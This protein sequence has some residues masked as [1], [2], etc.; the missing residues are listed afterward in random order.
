MIK[1]LVDIAV[2]APALLLLSPVMLVVAFC[3]RAT[4]GAPVLFRQMR[5]GLGFVPFEILKFRTMEAS[6]SG[7][8]V[9]SDGDPRVTA[10]G[11]VLRRTKLDEL[12]QLWNVLRGD[13]SLVGPRPEVPQYAEMFR[14][15]YAEL[16]MV[17]PGLTDPASVVFRNEARVLSSFADP[18]RAYVDIV[19]PRKLDLSQDY[20]RR[21]SMLLDLRIML[22]TLLALPSRNGISSSAPGNANQMETNTPRASW[23]RTTAEVAVRLQKTR[24]PTMAWARRSP[25]CFLEVAAEALE[26]RPIV[27]WRLLQIEYRAAKA[28][29]A[30]SLPLWSGYGNVS[31]SRTSDQVR[32]SPGIGATY[33]WL[34]R[35]KRPRRLVEIGT[36]FGIS[37]MYWLAGLTDNPVAHL[38]TFE[39]N[40]TWTRFA[41]RNLRSVSDQFTL[42]RAPFDEG[43]A[44]AWHSSERIDIAYI[45]GIHTRE[46]VLS[47]IEILRPWLSP[48]ALV[49]L[50]DID[51][52]PDMEDCWR[53]VVRDGSTRAALALDGHAGVVEFA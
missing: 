26:D 17:R 52:S 34:A 46:T 51:F 27:T 5:M 44:S 37:G 7:P 45:D 38:F 53:T 36:A 3:V 41:E 35:L 11:R 48:G 1:R 18:E 23:L 16:L 29:Q 4:S 15:R 24:R 9:T 30:G 40:E 43:F 25:G 22:E 21:R 31:E 32:T 49:V 50:D 8:S 20:V 39:P 28:A 19:L 10:V 13:M 42:V 2:A 33:S 12:P 14:A 6:S 47:Q